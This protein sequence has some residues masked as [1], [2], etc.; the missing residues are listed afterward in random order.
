MVVSKAKG[1]QEVVIDPDVLS[2]VVLLARVTE[3]GFDLFLDGLVLLLVGAFLLPDLSHGVA[4]LNVSDVS[5]HAARL[6]TFALHLCLDDS[7]LEV[8]LQTFLEQFDFELTYGLLF[9]TWSRVVG[10]RWVDGGHDLR[11]PVVSVQVVV[12]EAVAHPLVA[13]HESFFWHL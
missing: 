13:V 6:S 12:L 2:G 4:H 9:L 3:D 11:N 10:G 1:E 8:L 7:L 5:V